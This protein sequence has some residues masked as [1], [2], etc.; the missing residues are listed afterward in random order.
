MSVIIS[1]G[2]NLENRVAFLLEAKK[3]LSKN[4][5]LIEESN[6]YESPA[7]DY[8]NQPDFLNQVL[9]F[10][11]P[12]IS[13]EDFL[14]E[15]LS[16]ELSLGRERLID[17]GPRTIDIDILFWD[18]LVHQSA[19]LQIPHPR[20]FDRSFIV[21]PLKELTIFEKLSKEFSFSDTFEN[22]A[23]IFSPNA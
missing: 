12:E 21:Y 17:K 11:T 22:S 13:P 3:L 16:I 2:S 5:K 18:N 9:S 8:L 15:I 23:K 10:E 7:V 6:I 1:T 20:L 4:F 14:Q 19:N